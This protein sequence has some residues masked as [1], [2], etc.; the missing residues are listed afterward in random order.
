MPLWVVLVR[1]VSQLQANSNPVRSTPAPSAWSQLHWERRRSRSAVLW[2]YIWVLATPLVCWGHK[3]TFR[4][5]HSFA[6]HAS[7][8]AKKMHAIIRLKMCVVSLCK[9]VRVLKG[10]VETLLKETPAFVTA[11]KY[12]DYIDGAKWNDVVGKINQKVRRACKSWPT[13]H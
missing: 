4:Q 1:N 12:S 8:T 3:A 5:S 2:K 9:E 6:I 7:L 10:T 11:A 13:S